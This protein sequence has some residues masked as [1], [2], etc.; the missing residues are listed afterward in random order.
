MIAHIFLHTGLPSAWHQLFQMCVVCRVWWTTLQTLRL[1]RVSKFSWWLW[2]YS[3]RTVLLYKTML[4]ICDTALA[5]AALPAFMLYTWCIA[6]LYFHLIYTY[7]PEPWLEVFLTSTSVFCD[8]RD[9]KVSSDFGRDGSPT[10]LPCRPH[11]SSKMPA[12]LCMAVCI[13]QWYPYPLISCIHEFNISN[14]S[15][16]LSTPWLWSDCPLQ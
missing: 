2:V 4:S 3:N 10:G 15:H 14:I 8:R 16:W 9:Q 6:H 11:R 1:K 13:K 5:P 12:D 7:L